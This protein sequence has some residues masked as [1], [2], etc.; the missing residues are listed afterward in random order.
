MEFSFEYYQLTIKV[1]LILAVVVF[2]A[3]QY[4]KA[5]YGFLS[6]NNWGITIPNKI[7]WILMEVPVIIGILA[8]FTLSN[9][10]KNITIIL[11]TAIF[12]LHYCQRTFVFPFLIRGKSRMPIA[13]VL[14]GAA[15]NLV[16]AYLIG[17]WLYFISFSNGVQQIYTTN[18]L[19]SPQFI[20]GTIIF[21]F[22]FF[23]NLQSDSIIRNL[24]KPGDTKHYIPKGGFFKYVS[25]ANYFGEVLEWFGFAILTWSMPGVV[26]CLWTFANLGPRA[27]SLNKKYAAEFGEEFTKLKRKRILPFIY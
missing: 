26:F 18:W 13:I 20:I 12:L 4:F 9:N 3:L 24:R 14:M 22:G 25:S 1:M 15:F 6:N 10:E 11:I 7:G 19:Y 8:L 2:A 23:I 5:G 27:N 21:L 17:S 16:N